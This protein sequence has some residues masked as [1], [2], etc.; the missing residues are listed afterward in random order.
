MAHITYDL[1]DLVRSS[2][3]FTIESSGLA[4]DPDT[5]SV[6]Y[7]DPSGNVT[8]KVYGV[9][10]EVIKDGVGDYHIDINADEA[11]TWYHRWF[12][13][14]NIQ[15]AQEQH[16]DVKPAST[17]GTTAPV[18]SPTDTT[19]LETIKKQAL[20]N[21]VAITAEP[22]PTYNID[23]QSVSWDA[24]LKQLQSTVQWCNDRLIA[25]TPFEVDS[26]GTT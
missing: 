18:A 8:T 16:F 25:E 13:T 2:V 17:A 9:D 20:A 4:G 7:I 12:G 11:G 23:G 22:K 10:A 15:A 26:R 3:T 5:V 1:G 21:I 6:S 24:Y 14:G 19:Q